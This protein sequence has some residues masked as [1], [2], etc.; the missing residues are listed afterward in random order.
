MISKKLPLSLPDLRRPLAERLRPQELKDFIGQE[1]IL[2]PDKL[3][4]RAIVADRVSSMILWGPPGSGKTTLARLISKLTSSNFI[5]FSAAT[6]GIPEV[7]KLIAQTIENY[8]QSGKRT[9]LF[10]DEVHRFNKAQQDIFL[11]YIEDGTII[12]I[13]ATTENP[14]F[15]INS[16][17][18]SRARIFH[19]RE[20]SEESIEK[21][22]NRALTEK[23][24]GFGQ[25]KIN[26]SDSARE[27]IIRLSEGDARDALN[28][29]ELA[30][31][32]TK[33]NN[34]GVI[35]IDLKIA[36]EA[37]QAK[38]IR[39][40][41][42]AD[43]HFDAISA[44]HKS[45]R[46]SDVDAAIHY[47]ARMLEAGEDPLY[48]VRRLVRFAAEDIGIADPQALILASA[49]QQA[50]H[51]IGMPESDDIIAELV[52]YLAK[53]PKSRT[54]DS[55]YAKAKQDVLNKRL[56]PIPLEIRN[57][58]TKM[59]RDFGFGKDYKMYDKRSRL[60]ENIRR[61]KYWQDSK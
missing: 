55:A 2:G 9:I 58:P 5:N 22:I 8:D 50:V 49:V 27:H 35:D 13:G 53:A 28:V 60:P 24:Q 21:I 31:L 3:L 32:T 30:V 34:K 54:V 25:Q 6:S 23:E 61:Q 29:L 14:S 59:M 26:L 19:L 56:G 15:E 44:L 10:I 1:H 38:F 36:E 52:I 47:A 7:R 46:S 45:L 41:K 11:P 51:F 43:G 4:Y 57:A 39:Y 12:F 37:I 20:L 16:P 42:G 40:D 18:L 48:V 33:P 17:I